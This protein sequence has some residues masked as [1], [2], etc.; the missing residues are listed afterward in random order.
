[1]ANKKNWFRIIFI[2]FLAVLAIVS[3]DIGRRTTFPG[4]RPQLKE[5]IQKTFMNKDSVEEINTLDSLIR[6]D[7]SIS[8]EGNVH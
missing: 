8:K 4:S 7:D 2:V 3:Y 1:M 5:R 6:R